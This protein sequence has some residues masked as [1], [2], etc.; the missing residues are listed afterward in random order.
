MTRQDAT[1]P[2]SGEAALIAALIARRLDRIEGGPED[3]VADAETALAGLPGG[4]RLTKILA[5]F[6]GAE[7]DRALLLTCLA[8]QIDPPLIARYHAAT[9][10]GWCT[11][12]LAGRLFGLEGAALGDAARALRQWRLVAAHVERTGEPPALLPDPALRGWIAGHIG[13]EP[14]LAAVLSPVDPEP[15][16]KDWPVQETAARIA[17]ARRRGER[18]VLIVEGLAGAGRSLF[19]ACVA[20]VLGQ[21]ALAVR[22]ELCETTWTRGE[23]I[24]IQ[25]F[26]LVAGA[27]PVWRGAPPDGALWPAGLWPAP[28]QAVTLEPGDALPETGMLAPYHVDLPMMGTEERG[29]MIAARVPYADGWSG[30]TRRALA[31]RRALTPAAIA[32]LARVAPRTDA[33]A[34]EAANSAHAGVMGDLAQRVNG[35]LDWDDLVLPQ[36]ILDALKDLAFEAEMR[37]ATWS[38]PAI[39][40]LYAREAGLV[41]LFHGPPGTGKTMAA[42]VIGRALGLDIY[43]IDCSTVIS[44]YIGETAKNMRQI[45]ARARRIDAVLFFDEADA[46]FSRRTEVKDAHDRHANADTSYLLQLIEGEFEGVAILASN[47]M[48]DMDPA[49]LRRIRYLFEFPRP[50][51]EER[52]EIWK[53]AG[54]VL[55]D[56]APLWPVLGETL[57]L[58]G[59]QIKTTLLAAHFAALRR[60]GTLGAGDL[61]RAAEREFGK[62]G[63]TLGQRE[64]DRIRAHA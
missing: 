62:E 12:W 44:K 2:A 3:A 41:S 18:A 29:A 6:G 14:D 11:E 56:A 19:A 33:E 53:R 8:P 43:R 39:R 64:R 23:G 36:K 54:A 50:T 24:R 15:P 5:L 31:R 58:T 38:D 21:R 35:T 26:A 48:A 4:A 17:D 34:L 37:G 55:V 9:G 7:A 10:R 27:I 63:R 57:D 25:R 52:T 42:Q 49:F 45:F 20:R 30:A 61:L 1:R 13:I 28:V 59:A 16:L 32:R 40:R 46:L 51:A 47:R 22:P 60:G